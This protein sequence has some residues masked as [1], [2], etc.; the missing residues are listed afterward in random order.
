MASQIPL[1]SPLSD[2]KSPFNSHG[3]NQS[4]NGT[5]S[6]NLDPSNY[7]SG[8]G[9][10][11]D[12]SHESPRSESSGEHDIDYLSPR[13]VDK[14]EI[15]RIRSENKSIEDEYS[16]PPQK[17]RFM[18]KSHFGNQTKKVSINGSVDQNIHLASPPT[19]IVDFPSESTSTDL[20]PD[21][22]I[23]EEERAISISS[24]S[25][26]VTKSPNED[27]SY[28]LLQMPQHERKHL[29]LHVQNQQQQ[30]QQ[31]L[32]QSLIQNQQE[33]Q[34]L[35]EQMQHQ[36]AINAFMS[37]AAAH[38][39]HLIQRGQMGYPND[40][41]MQEMAH[42]VSLHGIKSQPQSR[43]TVDPLQQFYG[44]AQ[45]NNNRMQ[46]MM[47][48]DPYTMQHQSILSRSPGNSHMSSM[49]FTSQT[50]SMNAHPLEQQGKS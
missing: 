45:P 44:I 15:K 25:S 34:R 43:D 1:N 38:Y 30:Q 40:S 19:E 9:H 50:G 13:K 3:E 5:P 29:L 17:K 20:T 22:Q 2:N 7:V 16:P 32:Q 46:S 12:E 10:D 49:N 31:Q 28:K 21:D 6:N 47:Y 37:A 18:G 8:N 35:Q 48:L 14:S 33:S 42:L 24:S 26:S 27:L 4:S 36:Q 23:S 11:T 39:P 41:Q